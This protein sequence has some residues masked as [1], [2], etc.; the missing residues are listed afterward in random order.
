MEMITSYVIEHGKM[1]NNN[2][3]QKPEIQV[4][5]KKILVKKLAAGLYCLIKFFYRSTVL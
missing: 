3:K 4:I 5:G 1:K 2:L